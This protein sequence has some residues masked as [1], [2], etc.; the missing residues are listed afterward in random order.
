MDHMSYVAWRLQMSQAER[1]RLAHQQHVRREQV[2]AAHQAR[3]K[4]LAWR[5]RVRAV[6]AATARPT[7]T[8]SVPVEG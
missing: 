5:A 3:P 7:A 2:R 8:S 1:S 6:L 4:G